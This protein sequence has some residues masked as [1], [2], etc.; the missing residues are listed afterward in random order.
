MAFQKTIESS[1]GAPAE[2]HRVP[3]ITVDWTRGNLNGVVA[4]FYTQAAREANKGC[5]GSSE[6]NINGAHFPYP[7]ESLDQVRTLIGLAPGQ[8]L[9]NLRMYFDGP[10]AHCT[11]AIAV[12]IAGNV[13][14]SDIQF[15]IA[16]TALPLDFLAPIYI[17]LA[18]SAPFDDAVMV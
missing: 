18:K 9:L 4:S 15:Q 5:L 2:Y 11:A 16:K 8:A 12:D 1:T 14:N 13:A 17:L 6:F 7:S 3:S 10:T